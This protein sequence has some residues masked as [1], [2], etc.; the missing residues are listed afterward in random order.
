[1]IVANLVWHFHKYFGLKATS[2]A[3]NF[4]GT[5]AREVEYKEMP[6]KLPELMSGTLKVTAGGSPLI[7]PDPVESQPLK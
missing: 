6:S 3:K 7:P 2:E 5:G 1:M 4:T